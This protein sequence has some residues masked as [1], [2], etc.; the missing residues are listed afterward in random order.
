MK[1]LSKKFLQL[2]VKK[3]RSYFRALASKLRTTSSAERIFAKCGRHRKKTWALVVFDEVISGFRVA[4]GGMAEI[5][6]L[7]P[8][9]V[10]YGKI[11]G[12]GFPVG[13]YGGRADLMNLVAPQGPVYQAGTLSANPVECEQG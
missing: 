10:T 5:L 7:R 12:G 11:I 1:R 6:G 8:D 9:L 4:L 2:T 13:A 3:L